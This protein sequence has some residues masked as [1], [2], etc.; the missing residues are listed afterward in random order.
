MATQL[1]RRSGAKCLNCP[2]KAQARGCCMNCLHTAHRVI[3]SGER[4]EQELIDAGM[5]LPT[6]K[7]GRPISSPFLKKLARVK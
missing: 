3:R 5:I 7:K 1:K 6:Q 4:T 2:N